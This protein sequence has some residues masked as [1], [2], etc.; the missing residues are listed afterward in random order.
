MQISEGILLR[1]FISERD[2]KEGHCLSDW[3]VRKA[4]ELGLSGATVFRG[5]SGYGAHSHIHNSRIIDLSDN[6]PLV[7]E[8]V[9]SQEKIDALLPILDGAIKEGI[10]TTENVT[11]R[12]YKAQP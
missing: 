9:D 3:I 12:R 5:M 7:I 2:Q 4:R 11:L 8:I 10:A 6:M 1:V